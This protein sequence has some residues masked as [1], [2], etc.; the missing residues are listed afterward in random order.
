MK[1]IIADDHAIVREGLK[2]ILLRSNLIK[3]VDETENGEDLLAAIARKSYDVVILDISMP[4]RNG[5]EILKEIKKQRYQAPILMLSIHPEEQFA[6]RA[7]KN[8]AAGYLMKDSAPD[9]LISAIETVAS[10]RKFITPSLAEKLA[11]LLEE[12]PNEKPHEILSDREFQIFRLIAMGKQVSDI[13][14]ELNLSVKTISTYRTR[15]IEKTG[16]ANNA[17]ITRYAIENKL[18]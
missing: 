8:G 17:E 7:I 15:I 2:Q 12:S 11:D 10:G 16:F 14:P 5:L 13:A 9:E 4:G 1:I 3:T 18:V 6:V